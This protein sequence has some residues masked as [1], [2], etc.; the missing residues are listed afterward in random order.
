MC[1]LSVII[2]V[3]ASRLNINSVLYACDKVFYTKILIH[4]PFVTFGGE[5]EHKKKELAHC[6]FLELCIAGWDSESKS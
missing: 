3:Y 5:A 4:W 2:S 6:M 1:V